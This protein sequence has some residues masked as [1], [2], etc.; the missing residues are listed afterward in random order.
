MNAFTALM[1]NGRLIR[2][3]EDIINGFLDSETENHKCCCYLVNP[4]GTRISIQK[5]FKLEDYEYAI[6]TQECEKE[7]I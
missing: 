3:A 7:V 2:K 6:C 5:G 4:D 1:R